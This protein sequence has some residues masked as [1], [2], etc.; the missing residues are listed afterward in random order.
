MTYLLL[1]TKSSEVHSAFVMGKAR[2]APLK[3][4][5]IPRMELIAATMASCIDTLR[6]KE[7]QMDLLDFSTSV[8]KYI[9]NETSRFKVFVAKRVSQIF[10][11][12][13]P[14]QWRYVNTSSN[15]ADIA[16]RGMKVEVFVSDATWVSGPHFLLHP[17]SEWPVAR[18]D[19]YHLS[20]GDP[21][22]KGVVAVNV[23]QAR[24][25][26]VTHLIEYFSSWIR[27]KK[28]VAWLLRIKSWL[29]SCVKKTVTSNLCTV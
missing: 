1:K 10:Q 22:V 17:E 6:R 18:D 20:L 23:V 3:C 4:V 25:E 16:S 19:I 2:V 9:R 13:C 28:S 26:P 8:L 15:P 21:E 7:L 14:T 27:L 12:S 29:M 5:T 24:E 11:V